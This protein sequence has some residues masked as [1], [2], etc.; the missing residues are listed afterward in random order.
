[1]QH[2]VELFVAKNCSVC[3]AMKRM[4]QKL[5]EQGAIAELKLFDLE[6]NPQLAARYSIRS[7][8]YYR[9][10]GQGFSGLRQ[11]QEL[12][13]LLVTDPQSM[14][15]EWMAEQLRDGGL[16]Q[17]EDEVLQN[18]RAREALVQMLE[19][20]D[21]E[22]VVRIGLTAVIEVLAGQRIFDQLEDRFIALSRHV[23][24][25]IVIDAL[26]YLQLIST[27]SSLRQLKVLAQTAEGEVA[28]QARELL[29]EAL[30][31]S[32]AH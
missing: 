11:E 30:A 12:R 6:N 22:L 20:V 8:P 7:V 4:F 9:I 31:D 13:Q 29:H 28:E 27:P 10:N 26:Y 5:L 24:E 16:Q 18:P 3:P 21:T 23:E 19:S 15:A 25:R 17:V 14:L 2:T 1:M 32:V